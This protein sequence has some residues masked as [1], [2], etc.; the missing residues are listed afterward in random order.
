M[1][2]ILVSIKSPALIS[3]IF[4]VPFMIME[5]V[6]RR[7]FDQGFPIPL[8]IM[9]WLLPLLFIITLMPIVRSIRAGNNLLVSPVALL[10]RVVTLVFIA[11]MWTGIVLDQMPC[12]LG[13]PNCD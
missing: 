10:L 13:V 12:F 4:V 3:L 6:N 11:L 8:F 5:T 9:M 1:K 7:S 2:N